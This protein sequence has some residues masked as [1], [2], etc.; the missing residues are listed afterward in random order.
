MEVTLVLILL[1]ILAG[2]IKGFTGFGLSLV[3]M[4]VLF[5]MGYSSNEFLPIIVPLFVVL[6]LI[7][8]FEH[9]KHLKLDFKEN[10]TLH[11]TTLMTLFLGVLL[12]AYLIDKIDTS[13]MLL[14]FAFSVLILLFFLVQKIDV[15]HI[16]IPTE[17]ENGFFGFFSGILTGLFTLNG[18]LATIYMMYHQYPKEKYLANMVTFL[19]IS[20]IILIAV[21][22]FKGL[23]TISGL[24]TSFQL[25]IMVMIGFGL[26]I[27]LR[28]YVSSKTFKIV[29]IV[30]LLINSL[31]I[32]FDFFWFK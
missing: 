20:D 4:F 2:I 1:V 17:K 28:R 6:D 32:I 7:L 24:I 25:L 30:I 15:H 22:L 27:Y 29:T 18:I 5:E 11:P 3:L 16:K 26:G 23:F 8:Y 21:Y 10:F 9:R 13:Y 12:G 14:L 19:L 31:K